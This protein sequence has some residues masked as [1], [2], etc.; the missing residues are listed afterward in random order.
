MRHH[1]YFESRYG[2]IK[3]FS[4]NNLFNCLFN[5]PSYVPPMSPDHR[6]TLGVIWKWPGMTNNDK[7]EQRAT[8]MRSFHMKTPAY[9][10]LGFKKIRAINK[11]IT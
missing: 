7:D 1:K 9:N 4:E 2:Q 3:K 11:S 8:T 10:H 6:A 5:S